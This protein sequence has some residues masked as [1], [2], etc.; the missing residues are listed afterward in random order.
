MF[1]VP[2]KKELEEFSPEMLQ[3]NNVEN[4]DGLNMPFQ[5]LS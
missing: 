1:Y 3:N 5:Y 4:M 2:N